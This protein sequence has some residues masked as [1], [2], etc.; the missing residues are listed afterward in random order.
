[1]PLPRL[2][3]ARHLAD[4]HHQTQIGRKGKYDMADFAGNTADRARRIS[5]TSKPQVFRDALDQSDRN[6]FYRFSIG[7]R[8]SFKLNLSGIA[9]GA[10]LN[11]ELRNSQNQVLARSAQPGGLNEV[12]NQVLEKGIY[13]I[14]AFRKSGNSNYKLKVSTAPP[15]DLAGNTPDTARPITVGATSSVYSD[16]VSTDTDN[17][18]Y[19]S[20]TLTDKTTRLSSSL[21]GITSDVQVNLFDRTNQLIASKSSSTTPDFELV[22][23]AGSYYAQVQPLNGSTAY[24]LSLAGTAIP[25]SAGET[26]ATARTVFL[27]ST[28]TTL[29]EF[30]GKGD[31][32]D[33]YKFTVRKAVTLNGAIATTPLLPTDST[34]LRVSLLKDNNGVLASYQS[35]ID[36]TFSYSLSPGVYYIKVNPIL[37]AQANY[38]LSLSAA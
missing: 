3:D 18:D 12:M 35:S 23:G 36:P 5:L 31:S 25:D 14:R 33:Y 22:L 8:S 30:V 17:S 11:V 34:S 13:W 24:K 28:P 37:E 16:F 7:K 6:D 32:E 4:P 21:S 29:S 27:S 1:M 15:P 38:N 26:T 2:T 20:F 9:A 10:D 19:Y